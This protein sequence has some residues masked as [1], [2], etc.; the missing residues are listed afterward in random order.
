LSQNI[1]VFQKRLQIAQ[2]KWN[3]IHG[4]SL[5]TVNLILGILSRINLIQRNDVFSKDFLLKF[6]GIHEKLAFR[7]MES[8]NNQIY[9]LTNFITHFEEVINEMRKIE[10]Q[11]RCDVLS[12]IK[13]HAVNSKDN[14]PHDLEVIDQTE[15]TM[16][17]IID[18]YE[19]ELALRKQIIT[20]IQSS[21][22]LQPHIVTAHL[23]L[24]LSNVYIEPAKI[25]DLIEEFGF[26]EKIYS[27]TLE[28]D[29]VLKQ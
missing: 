6:D 13:K 7:L 3:T 9:E 20:E 14:W 2:K 8:T 28:Q 22:P 25:H 15:Q 4:Q 27:R 11:F 16:H 26:V 29:S 12:L 5:R 24:W 18:M 17:Q 23:N 10:K 21:I 19:T 1:R